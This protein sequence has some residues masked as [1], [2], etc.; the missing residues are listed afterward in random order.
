MTINLDI[1]RIPTAWCILDVGGCPPLPDE[2][3]MEVSSVRVLKPA[4]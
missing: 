2:L 4:A 3:V 1:A